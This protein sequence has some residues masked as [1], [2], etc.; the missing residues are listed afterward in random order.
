[1]YEELSLDLA[2]E[3]EIVWPDHKFPFVLLV[4]GVFNLFCGFSPYD[5]VKAFDPFF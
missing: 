3:S 5:V 4:G 1:M 2:G